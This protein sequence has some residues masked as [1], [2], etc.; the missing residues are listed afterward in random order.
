MDHNSTVIDASK[1]MAHLIDLFCYR[2]APINN[3]RDNPLR[4]LV[5]HGYVVGF[6][7]KNLQPAWSAYRVGE[8]TTGGNDEPIEAWYA[9]PHSYYDDPRLPPE[10]RIGTGT[11]RKSSVDGTQM[12]LDVGHM[13]PNY[14]IA[15]Q[16]GPLAQMETFF[17]SNMS[18]QSRNLNQGYWRLMEENIVDLYRKE[19][20]HIWI[21]AGP[22]FKPQLGVINRR[23]GTLQIPIPSHY[24]LV[25]VGFDSRKRKEV[26]AIKVSQGADRDIFR[27][28]QLTS[29]ES[30]ERETK[31]R[32]FP[33]QSDSVHKKFITKTD[34]NALW[35]KLV[36]NL[37]QLGD[38]DATDA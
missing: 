29:V 30:I 5:N 8:A 20:E 9:R 32:F 31:L 35:D 19:S 34:K 23:R 22:I 3:D 2:G 25:A 16:F 33:Q 37:G 38:A 26:V 24:F 6:S 27:Y 17:M 12:P 36:Q 28:S 11:F 4:I 7:P 10:Y 14:A 21:V 13:T 15:K 1:P 18:P